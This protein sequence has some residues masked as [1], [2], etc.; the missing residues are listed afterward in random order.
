MQLLIA[1]VKLVFMRILALW[2]VIFVFI[3][4]KHVSIQLHNVKVVYQVAIE[5]LNLIVGVKMVFMKM[6][7]YFVNPVFTHV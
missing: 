5:M 2:L 7:I 6:K 3:H 1:I 4:A